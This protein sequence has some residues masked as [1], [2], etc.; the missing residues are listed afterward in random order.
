ML[1]Q[2]LGRYRLAARV[3]DGPDA[4]VWEAVDVPLR[5]TVRAARIDVDGPERE[6]DVL[7]QARA[8]A[9][10]SNPAFC[11]I[12][13]VAAEDGAIWIV[14]EN[15]HGRP[16]AAEL[17]QG[18]IPV[19][20]VARIGEAV[21]L[22]LQ[23]ARR[24]GFIPSSLG[25]RHLVRTPSGRIAIDTLSLII[26][27]ARKEQRPVATAPARDSGT[28]PSIAFDLRL[29]GTLLAELSGSAR[30]PGSG[31]TAPP[32]APVP[33]PLEDLVHRCVAD[34]DDRF[35]TMAAAAVALRSLR[36]AFESGTASLP[37]V[38][39]R[40]RRLPLFVAAA[41]VGAVA[42]LAA[43]GWLVARRPDTPL[44]VAVMP[45]QA[46]VVDDEPLVIA[47]V[48]E[49]AVTSL[50][51]ITPGRVA[52]PSDVNEAVRAGARASGQIAT[53]LGVREFIEGSATQ[54]AAGGPIRVSVARLATRGGRLVW[55]GQ[56][57]IH[58]ADLAAVHAAVVELVTSAFEAADVAGPEP[59]REDAFRDYLQAWEA[60]RGGAGVE[61]P[62]IAADRAAAALSEAPTFL[63][64]ALL[65]FDLRLSA[66]RS[67]RDPATLES[68]PTILRRASAV[69]PDDAPALAVRRIE[70]DLA[71]GRHARAVELA[72]ALVAREQRRLAAWM[73]LGHALA[74]SGD[75]GEAEEAFTRAHDLCPAWDILD[76]IAACRLGRN[77]VAG[78]REAVA[79]IIDAG[80]DRPFAIVRSAAIAEEE[81]DLESAASARVS[82]ARDR[83]LP[84]DVIRAG[85][86]LLAAGHPAQAADFLGRATA[87]VPDDAEVVADLGLAL[88]RAGHRDQAH[89]RFVECVRI[90]DRALDG[91]AVD[92]GALRARAICRA[93][94]GD[95][96]R[97]LSD[98]E[99]SVELDPDDPAELYRA[100]L[101]AAVAADRDRCIGWTRR[102]LR[103][104]AS[105]AWFTSPEFVRMWN[106]PAFTELFPS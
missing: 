59:P 75:W 13:E 36:R 67:S 1:P 4:R 42:I 34:D 79:P 104:G 106:D 47:A 78:A 56:V 90:A 20:E 44:D 3:S 43:V 101:V 80:P 105:A 77:D 32:P 58:E 84:A 7:A 82:L 76:C 39:S 72:R 74:A 68:L 62:R 29:L 9:A 100:A 46:A 98:A 63:D 55:S 53:L 40:V 18:P 28:L 12:Y 11:H 10:L 70:L 95:R 8:V 85:T 94:V 69:A 73:A 87:L 30:S 16:V 61:P 35:P 23:D 93:F 22:A 17:E 21:A 49:A 65:L 2:R 57:D 31:A 33:R 64:A 41:A 60:T 86:A 51:R 99:T 92:V 5:R 15:L 6:E 88:E 91:T 89:R 24:T 54:A 27:G 48:E 81:G 19:A 45:V 50:G 71:T 83:G 26:E 97:A 38:R 96:T 37:A 25:P 14:T 102:A 66:F 103:C 52:T